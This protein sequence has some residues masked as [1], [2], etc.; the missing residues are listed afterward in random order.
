MW[1]WPEVSGSSE[2]SGQSGG[3]LTRCRSRGRGGRG[4]QGGAGG[5]HRGPGTDSAPDMP[6]EL[7]LDEGREEE[8]Q[9]RGPGTAGLLRSL[10]RLLALGLAPPPEAVLCL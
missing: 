4:G 9:R 10:E 5:R 1:A 2:G 3:G 8:E 6:P 7:P